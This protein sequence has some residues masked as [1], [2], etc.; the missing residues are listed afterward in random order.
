M[1]RKKFGTRTL[2]RRSFLKSVGA[3][4]AAFIP[5]IR[6]LAN[7]T[8]SQAAERNQAFAQSPAIRAGINLGDDEATVTTKL[9]Q[10]LLVQAAQGIGTPEWQ[11]SDIIVR[12]WYVPSGELRV[13]QV[14]LTAPSAGATPEG[15][16]VGSSVDNVKRAYGALIKD[17]QEAGFVVPLAA[18]KSLG[19]IH[20]NESVTL[21]VLEDLTCL[22][23]SIATGP[24]GPRKEP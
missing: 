10:P 19:I 16:Q 15:I 13:K 4:L 6:T 23:C 5:A 7:A 11:Y 3:G 18:G 20:T 21:I 2:L 8:G 22:N 14:L 17:Y 24:Q 1:K 9:G 12:F